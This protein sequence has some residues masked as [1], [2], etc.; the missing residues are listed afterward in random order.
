MFNSS[1]SL[2]GFM[3]SN[4]AVTEKCQHSTRPHQVD[5]ETHPNLEF[6]HRRKFELE[7]RKAIIKC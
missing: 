3:T 7:K 4:P 5:L 2:Y 6:R 1:V